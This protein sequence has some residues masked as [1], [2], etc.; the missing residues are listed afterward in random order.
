MRNA[1]IQQKKMA[2][3]GRESR[4]SPTAR[5]TFIGFLLELFLAEAAEEDLH[6]LV[7]VDGARRVLRGGANTPGG[8]RDP[9]FRRNKWCW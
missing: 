6:A 3:I 4:E 8:K 7:H 1:M 9:C 2:Q 5:R